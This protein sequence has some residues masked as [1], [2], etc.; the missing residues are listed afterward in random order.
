VRV[1]Q[2]GHKD[3]DEWAKLVATS[4]DGSIY[5][6]PAYLDVLCRAAGGRY[7]V[8]AVRNAHELEGGVALYE[9]DSRIGPYVSPRRLLYYNGIVLRRYDTKYP[10]EQ[11]A[12]SIRTMT[13]LA[14]ELRQ[15]EYSSVTLHC[16]GSL[17]DVR[18]FVAAGWSAIPQYTYVVPVAD[19]PALWER[20]EKNLRRLVR[21]CEREGMTVSADNDFDSFFRLHASTMDRKG[22][23]Y[24]LPEQAFR[25]YFEALTSIGMCQLFHARLAS[26]RPVATQFVLLG[27]GAV[28][29]S[30][31]AA[32]DAEFV[33]TGVSALL[34]WRVFE[35]M[36]AAGYAANDLTDAS[37]NAVT[38]FKSQLGGDLQLFF[39]LE[40]PRTLRVRVEQGAATLCRRGLATVAAAVRRAAGRT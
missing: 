1:H 40:S 28:S 6:L 16:R 33:R 20:V 7:S 17:L 12:R 38:H 14:G 23:G 10:S 37:L 25:N 15:R 30:V 13:A 11:T 27:P 31:A 4:P 3:Y 32:V 8:L 24:Y 26:G 29:H 21:R 22:Q 19:I 9:R 36:S 5:S 2:V 35:A 18:P 34:R 39:S